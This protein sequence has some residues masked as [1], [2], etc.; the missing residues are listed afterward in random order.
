M[1]AYGCELFLCTGDTPNATAGKSVRGNY[2]AD[3]EYHTIEFDLTGLDFWK[4]TVHSIRYD[5]FNEC[6]D[7]DEIFIRSIRLS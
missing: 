4:G 3:G 2:I 7:G 6:A 1:S 5:F